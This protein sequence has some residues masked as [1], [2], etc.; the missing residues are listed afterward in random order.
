M[1]TV[2]RLLTIIAQVRRVEK[3]LH[4]VIVGNKFDLFKGTDKGAIY[5]MLDGYIGFHHNWADNHQLTSSK[6]NYNIEK[7]LELA[8]DGIL[9]TTP[10]AEMTIAFD[11]DKETKETSVTNVLCCCWKRFKRRD[12]E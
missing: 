5:R 1:E 9:S 2:A 4:C 10:A 3:P 12:S 8:V 11:P 7:A 6:Y